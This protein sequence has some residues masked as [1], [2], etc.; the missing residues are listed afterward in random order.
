MASGENF[1]R[2]VNNPQF[3]EKYAASGRLCLD[4]RLRLSLQTQF[5]QLSLSQQ[6]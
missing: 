2:Q 6:K 1:A 3:A 4:A 5:F